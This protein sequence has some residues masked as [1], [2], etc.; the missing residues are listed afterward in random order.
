MRPTSSFVA[1]FSRRPH[2]PG[3]ARRSDFVPICHE[4]QTAA[5]HPI[6][7]LVNFS[8]QNDVKNT[9]VTWA[10]FRDSKGAQKKLEANNYY[11][12]NEL[13]IAKTPHPDFDV[14]PPTA[15]GP[16]PVQCPT[17]LARSSDIDIYYEVLGNGPDLVLLHPFP[18]HH[19]VWMPV[20]EQLASK[21]RVI[22]PDLRGHGESGVGEGA[23]TMEKHAEDL[24]RVLADAQVGK[25]IFAG[26]SIG[27]YILFEFWR[28]HRE[29][30]KA[31]VLCN[32]KATPDTQDARKARLQSAEDVL[33]KGV[34]PFLDTMLPKLLGETTR[35]HR[36]DIATAAKAMMMKITPAGVAAV[37]RGMA[38]RPDSI[39]TLGTIN[40]PTLIVGAGEDSIP[41]SE[42]ELM[43]QHT[44]GA[45]LRVIAK[46]GHYAVFERP[47]E[48]LRL[49]RQFIDGVPA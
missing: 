27:G 21:Y 19:G 46:A 40:V 37:Q 15:A 36:P 28:R 14:A 9:Q 35:F 30:V 29:R 6:N 23:A 39:P 33:K 13:V 48:A 49:I 18:A 44:R 38:E 5:A 17:M 3:P 7:S 41:L 2:Q 1:A 4:T 26:E 31:L 43:K 24:V 11:E 25:A 45:A 47:D 32:T 22:V 12:H 20:A 42:A 10:Y 16:S 34:E 8:A